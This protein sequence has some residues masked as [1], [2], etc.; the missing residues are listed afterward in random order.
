MATDIKQAGI[1]Q[2]KILIDLWNT[3]R[4]YVDKNNDG[5]LQYILL[6]GDV[7]SPEAIL[8]TKDAISTLNEVG[9]KTEQLA[10]RYCDWKE[11]CSKSAMELLFFNYGNKIEAIISNNDAM[12]IGSIKTLQKYGYNKGDKAKTIPV[13]GIDGIT[14]AKEL[15]NKGF[16]AGTVVQ[17]PREKAEVFYLAAQNMVLGIPPLLNTKYKFDETGIVIRLPYYE[18]TRVSGDTINIEK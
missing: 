10:L 5:I 2:G 6:H 12:A 7:D 8:R 14:E 9:I 15:I 11:E 1:L 4:E 18:Y 13:V 17:N 16:M 3:G